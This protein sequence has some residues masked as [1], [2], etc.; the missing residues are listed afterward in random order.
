M[1][2]IPLDIKDNISYR[3][4]KGEIKKKSANPW[5]RPFLR[6]IKEHP[7][8]N[9]VEISRDLLADN[10][11]ARKSAVKN[12]LFFFSQSGL[13][14]YHP[15]HGY[16]LTENGMKALED[17]FVWQGKKGSFMITL[18]TPVPDQNPIILNIAEVPDS[19]YDNGKND[20]E[21]I[22]EAYGENYSNVLL[23][24]KDVQ[25]IDIGKRTRISYAKIDFTSALDPSKGIVGVRTNGNVPGL[26]DYEIIFQLPKDILNGLFTNSSSEDD[27]AF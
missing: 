2:N 17:S 22:P 13:L 6:Y 4:I 1:N 26:E 9:E 11:H 15:V 16:E 20:L 7:N 23:A 5:I 12:I 10:G 3:I 27:F 8:T 14:D 25:L 18:W 21:E 19:W 24:P